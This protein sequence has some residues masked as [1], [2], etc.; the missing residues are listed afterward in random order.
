MS[1][2]ALS[3]ALR[4]VV[5]NAVEAESS[6]LNIDVSSTEQEIA[7][8]VTDNGPGMTAEQVGR[9]FEPFFTTKAKGTGLGLAISRQELEDAGGRLSCTSEPGQGTTFTLHLPTQRPA[10]A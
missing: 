4:N 8:R 3:R 2:D 7:I 1:G 6:T 9:V 10:N 5:R